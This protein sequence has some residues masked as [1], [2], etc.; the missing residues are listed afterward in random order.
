M[1]TE[2]QYELVN[3][4]T[5]SSTG[6]ITQ[7]MDFKMEF[8]DLVRQLITVQ[9][10]QNELL[11]EIVNQM[12]A[13]QRQRN[14]ELAQWK[15]ANPVLANS[16][17][18]AA[19]CLGKLQTEVLTNLAYDIDDNFEILQGNEYQLSEFFEKYGP[20]LIHLNTILQTLSVLGN[21]PDMANSVS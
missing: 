1:S 13:S 4:L 3:N 20:K 19:D 10:R 14:Q 15:R 2:P 17:K 8:S 7:S 21:A 16:C 11:Q 12:T 5:S 6:T 18:I 9:T